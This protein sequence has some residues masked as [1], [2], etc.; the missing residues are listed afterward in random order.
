VVRS[1]AIE[2][3]VLES[4]VVAEAY[5]KMGALLAEAR[6][7]ARE[8]LKALLQGL[9]EVIE[10]RPNAEDAKQGQAL[11]ELLPPPT[12]WQRDAV[13]CQDA[14]SSSCPVWL[15]RRVSNPRP[16]G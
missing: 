4:E 7:R 14:G 10:W 3:D 6:T 2:E 13:R 12:F 5:A 11:I 9:V 8:E 15:R 16:G 1:Q